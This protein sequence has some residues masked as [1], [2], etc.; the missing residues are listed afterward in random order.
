M[1]FGHAWNGLEWSH[2]ENGGKIWWKIHRKLASFVD[3]K[4]PFYLFDRFCHDFE[5]NTRL[6]CVSRPVC[7]GGDGDPHA[8]DARCECNRDSDDDV[9]RDRDLRCQEHL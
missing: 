4:F 2:A 1:V 5:S 6:S 9:P 3:C 7:H 8:R